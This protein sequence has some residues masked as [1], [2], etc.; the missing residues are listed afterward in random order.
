MRSTPG[1]V[2]EE[3]RGKASCQRFMNIY[4]CGKYSVFKS[5]ILSRK[6]I[7]PSFLLFST[8]I[9]QDDKIQLI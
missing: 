2:M 7:L 5:Q 4:H 3:E 1:D 9:T 8:V 6:K